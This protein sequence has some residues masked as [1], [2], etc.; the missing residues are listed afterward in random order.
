MPLNNSSASADFLTRL[1]QEPDDCP[2]EGVFRCGSLGQRESSD[3]GVPSDHHCIHNVGDIRLSEM[4]ESAA[5]L[6]LRYGSN[7]R[8]RM[9]NS[10]PS[11]VRT[12]AV[13]HR[14]T[15]GSAACRELSPMPWF[16]RKP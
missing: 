2:Q 9:P 5:P 16:D 4:N 8:D 11:L 1:S 15:R 10:A 13:Q 6:W 7:L 12:T 3:S 14:G